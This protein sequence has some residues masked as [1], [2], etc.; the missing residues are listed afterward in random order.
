[1]ATDFGTVLGCVKLVAVVGVV[2][3]CNQW[4]R[5]Y[6]GYGSVNTAAAHPVVE[7]LLSIVLCAVLVGAK[8]ENSCA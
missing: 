7:L 1:M 2:I 3:D 6:H 4:W 8:S 5:D